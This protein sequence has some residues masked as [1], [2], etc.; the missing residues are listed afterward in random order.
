MASFS[1]TPVM[2]EASL[3]G[4]YHTHEDV[5]LPSLSET[6]LG[7]C[8]LN[9]GNSTAIPALFYKRGGLLHAYIP[10]SPLWFF[11]KQLRESASSLSEME[12]AVYGPWAVDVLD[13]RAQ[14]ASIELA[15]SI[16]MNGVDHKIRTVTR[17]LASVAHHMCS[18]T[19]DI[20]LAA[21]R[22]YQFAPRA[23]TIGALKAGHVVFSTGLPSEC[24]TATV[25]YDNFGLDSMKLLI[26]SFFHTQNQRVDMPINLPLV[27]IEL[28]KWPFPGMISV[29]DKWIVNTYTD[30]KIA[31]D[32]TVP[33]SDGEC[34]YI[35]LV[36]DTSTGAFRYALN[37]S[38]IKLD[39]HTV[40]QLLTRRPPRCIFATNSDGIILSFYT[41]M[42]TKGVK[43]LH[44][45]DDFSSGRGTGDGR[46]DDRSTSLADQLRRAKY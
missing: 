38:L 40:L 11:Y 33:L 12:R 35:V 16:D 22:F 20:H 7:G 18:V 43:R 9:I 23:S 13:A 31:L 25:L 5:E 46:G 39:F 32:K 45:G 17:P 1:T 42:N 41:S 2:D 44:M 4:T 28:P 37:S 24:G 10:N 26:N 29:S 19:S 14:H 21:F 6:W 3:Y 27:T 34:D 8:M 36:H 15:E 30:S